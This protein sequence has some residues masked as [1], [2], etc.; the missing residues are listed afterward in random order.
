[1]KLIN[2]LFSLLFIKEISCLSR[3]LY[4]G[5]QICFY[6]NYFSQMNIVFTY[7]ILDQDLKLKESH[8]SYFEIMINGVEKSYFKSFYG[9]KLY[10]KFSY[11][12]EVSD[13][14]QICI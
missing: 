6:D 3:A 9:S 12:I 4:L 11:N 5:K 8:K 10:G 2:I 1:M 13:K 14:Y 7:K